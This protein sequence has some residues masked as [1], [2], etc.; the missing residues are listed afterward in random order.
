MDSGPLATHR[1]ITN[2]RVRIGGLDIAMVNFPQPIYL[3]PGDIINVE[4]TDAD[5]QPV[6]GDMHV[7]AKDSDIVLS[8][9][10]YRL[11]EDFKE[12]MEELG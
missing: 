6:S 5:G 8:P 12:L 1:L 4:F 7:G 9:D 11:V 10:D 2:I 3:K